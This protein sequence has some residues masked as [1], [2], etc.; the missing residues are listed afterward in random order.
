MDNI[1]STTSFC[2]IK[3]VT[4]NNNKLIERIIS[5]TEFHDFRKMVGKEVYNG[6]LAEKNSDSGY[7]ETLQNFLDN[8]IYKAIA[9]LAY[10]NYLLQ[11]EII[12]TYSGPVKKDNP[13]SEHIDSG[14]KKN[15]Y[16]Y[17]RDI[18]YE[19]YAEIKEQVEAYFNVNSCERDGGQRTDNLHQIVGLRKDYKGRKIEITQL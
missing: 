17:N 8:G 19:I 10:A 6:I 4:T 16:V 7:S 1:L 2:L 13:Y 5:E 3:G 14:T 12:S 15:L 11:G 9:Y 18:A